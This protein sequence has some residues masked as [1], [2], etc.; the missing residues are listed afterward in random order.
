MRTIRYQE[1]VIPLAPEINLIVKTEAGNPH[2][3]I[4]YRY[5]ENVIKKKDDFLALIP[6]DDKRINSF[7]ADIC[8][9]WF[10]DHPYEKGEIEP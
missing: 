7:V 1:R 8:K 4:F 10:K 9:D 6:N 5:D 3:L 2:A